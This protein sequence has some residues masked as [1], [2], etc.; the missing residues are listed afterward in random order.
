MLQ[1]R[2]LSK[3]LPSP[4]ASELIFLV[5]RDLAMVS[6]TAAAGG[7]GAE[8]EVALQFASIYTNTRP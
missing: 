8:G 3:Y 1:V 6:M 4:G 5:L 7:V 2:E